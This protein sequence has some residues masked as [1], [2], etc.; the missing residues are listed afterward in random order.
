MFNDLLEKAP[1]RFDHDEFDADQMTSIEIQK[2]F[3]TK[4]QRESTGGI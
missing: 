1:I 4:D 3:Q 2:E